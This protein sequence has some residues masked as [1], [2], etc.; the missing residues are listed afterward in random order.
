MT[1]MTKA[2]IE[3]ARVL[4][5]RRIAFA[6]RV[7]NLL[8][9][10]GGR[11]AQSKLDDHFN[12][13]SSGD[14]VEYGPKADALAAEIAAAEPVGRALHAQK[15]EAVRSA[16]EDAQKVI[17]RVRK[18][19]EAAEWNIDTVAPQPRSFHMSREE[20]QR[21]S[22]KRSLFSSLTERQDPRSY[23]REAE[24]MVKMSDEGIARFISNSEQDA[25][26]QYDAFICK[27]VSKVGDVKHATIDGEH[28]WGHSILTVVLRGGDTDGQVQ[29]WKTQQIVN[30][31]VYGRPY[32]QWPSRIVK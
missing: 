18:E 11:I 8:G 5:N 9:H 21:A 31:S 3:A 29:R 32:L 12:A 14:Q 16:R 2:Q 13:L 19:L 24:K 22:A 17:E 7:R 6:K 28:V 15:V 4:D 26:L 20:Y 1:T 25:A 30:Y 23:S 10:V 27:M